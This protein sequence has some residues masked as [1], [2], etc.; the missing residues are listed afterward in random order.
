MLFDFQVNTGWK[1]VG[2]ASLSSPLT[3]NL[4]ALYYS[5]SVPASH[6]TVQSLNLMYPLHFLCHLL[7][8]HVPLAVPCKGSAVGTQPQENVWWARRGSDTPFPRL[9][10]LM[11]PRWI[12][13]YRYIP[14]CTSN[15]RPDSQLPFGPL[16]VTYKSFYPCPPQCLAS[17]LS[18]SP[19]HSYSSYDV[20]LLL[21][22]SQCCICLHKRCINFTAFPER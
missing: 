13:T 11:F 3:R 14:S 5:S 10:P 1:I 15:T 4:A 8:I 9:C 7:L 20:L 19:L 6:R 16:E 18:L 12:Q 17:T 22:V 21:Q 2:S